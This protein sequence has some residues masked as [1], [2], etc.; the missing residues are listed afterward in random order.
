[1]SK[2][3]QAR[4]KLDD[5]LNFV[6]PDGPEWVKTMAAIAALDQAEVAE[7]AA[8]FVNASRGIDDAVA[9]LRAIVAGAT[10]NVASEFIDRV[11]GALGELTPVV[12]NVTALLSGEPASALPGMEETNQPMFPTASEP[13][14]PPVKDR[15]RASNGAGTV[16]SGGNNVDQMIDDILRREG[17]FVN[18]VNDRGGPTNFGVAQ[19]T[20]AAWR[21]HDVSVDDVRNLS[22]DEA[23]EIYRANYYTRP[24][25]DLLPELI[26]P[27][28]FDMS[29]NHGP[30]TAVK[31]L[32]RVLN[33]TG[34]ACSVD[35]GIGNQTIGGAEAA[36]GALGD[37]LINKLVD[38]RI[39]FYEAIVAG[40]ASQGV[41]LRGWLNRANEFSVA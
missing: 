31:L 35:G 33:D 7:A 36:A 32:Q 22:Q 21:G 9:K 19:R 20:L 34:N 23:R 24:K 14:V 41:F 1:M 29:I 17:G 6:M 16:A 26:Q 10:P 2:Y 3:T 27:I 11:N 30:G 40:D 39:A 38:E 15:S 28:M 37:G 8:N 25:I 18:H 5:A 4:R 12:E 13:I